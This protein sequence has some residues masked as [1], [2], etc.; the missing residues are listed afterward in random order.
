MAVLASNKGHSKESKENRKSSLRRLIADK[1]IRYHQH[2]KKFALT[3]NMIN[4][5]ISRNSS[6]TSSL[7]PLSWNKRSN[8][9][10]KDNF[11]V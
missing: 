3:S 6:H 9:I 8:N 5:S 2:L 10:N 1:T 7:D 11:H 4:K